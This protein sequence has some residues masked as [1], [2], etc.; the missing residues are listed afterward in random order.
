VRS[1][2]L[3]S[4]IFRPPFL[5]SENTLEIFPLPHSAAAVLPCPR[6]LATCMER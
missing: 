5:F 6:R 4:I 2:S 3:S 1:P